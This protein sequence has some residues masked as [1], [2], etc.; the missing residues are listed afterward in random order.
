MSYNLSL[1]QPLR[2]PVLFLIFNRPLTTLRVFNEIRNARPT[3]LYVAGDGPRLSHDDEA[4][5]VAQARKIATAVDWH[6]DL[7]TRFHESNLGCK[8]AV[9]SAISWFFEH[10]KQGIILEDDCLPS[11]SFFWFCENLLNRYE[12]DN[13]I[14]MISGYNKQQTWRQKSCDY[15]FSNLGGVWGWASWRRAWTLYDPNMDDLDILIKQK[16]FD[17]LLGPRAG[18]FRAKQLLKAKSGNISGDIS[19]WAYPWGF[20]RHKHNGLSC[21]PCHSLISNIG[22]GQN[23]THTVGLLSDHVVHCDL[24]PPLRYNDNIEP[25]FHYDEMFLNVCDRSFP[26]RLLRSVRDLIR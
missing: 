22:F 20:S 6:C 25:D 2:T 19:S 5:R 13:R 11:S 7:K 21:V 17:R 23:A 8:E 16:Y 1:E 9:S 26:R 14:M 15:F 10:E 24:I 4:E 18:P 12:Y 3:R